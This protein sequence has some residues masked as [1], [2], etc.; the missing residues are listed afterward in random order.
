[1]KPTFCLAIDGPAGSGKSS[2]ARSIAK[3]KPL[4]HLDS[5]ALYR[6]VTLFL[7]EKDHIHTRDTELEELLNTIHFQL[8]EG[9]LFYNGE[10]IGEEIRTPEVGKWTSP[11]STLPQVR[12][13]VNRS[14]R[15]MA[16]GKAI[17]MDGRDIGTVVFPEADLKVYLDATPEERALRRIREWEQQGIYRDLEETLQEIK[18]RDDR[19]SKRA[20]APLKPAQDAIIIDTTFLSFEDVVSTI[21]S[22]VDVL[23][24]GIAR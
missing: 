3:L 22:W 4:L 24:K 10:P 21:V 11:I 12:E 7:M 14:I 8:I 17:V 5:G 16:F 23:M 15:E 9:R 1:M 13:K 19:D 2:V 18:E 6:R 20:N